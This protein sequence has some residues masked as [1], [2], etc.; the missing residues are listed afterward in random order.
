MFWKRQTDLPPKIWFTIWRLMIPHMLPTWRVFLETARK[1]QAGLK[2]ASESTELNWLGLACFDIPPV[3]REGLPGLSC[4]LTQSGQKAGVRGVWKPKQSDPQNGVQLIHITITFITKI[5]CFIAK[6][7]TRHFVL[8]DQTH[9]LCLAP[10]YT[11][12]IW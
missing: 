3:P 10:K 5:A 2:T 9:R 11:S 7:T 12:K 1:L 8:L 4:K 6:E